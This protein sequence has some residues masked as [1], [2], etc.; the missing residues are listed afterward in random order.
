MFL[1]IPFILCWMKISYVRL[2]YRT[3]LLLIKGSIDKVL[4][5]KVFKNYHY[6]VTCSKFNFKKF[7]SFDSK[8]FNLKERATFLIHCWP[9]LVDESFVLFAI[10]PSQKNC[11]KYKIG[12]GKR[13]KLRKADHPWSL[14]NSVISEFQR[15]IDYGDESFFI[16]PDLFEMAKDFPVCWNK[17]LWT[18]W[19]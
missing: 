4:L 15:D 14:V 17:L 9:F 11:Q 10:S 16:W 5:V 3:K 6:K 19:N 1:T 8:P 12:V 18:Q 7:G 13:A 2:S